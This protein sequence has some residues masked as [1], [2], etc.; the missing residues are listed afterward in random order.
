[1]FILYLL[2]DCFDTDNLYK[3]SYDNYICFGNCQSSGSILCQ[4][5][6]QKSPE[7]FIKASG[8]VSIE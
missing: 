3:T 2:I 4:D 1:M 5:P 7:N 6:D 8:N